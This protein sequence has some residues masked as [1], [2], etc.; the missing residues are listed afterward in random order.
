MP[1]VLLGKLR[2]KPN[3]KQVWLDWCKE[4]KRRKNEAIA[5]LKNA[6]VFSEACFISND[7]KFVYY[8]LEAKDVE[9]AMKIG[10]KSKHPIDKKTQKIMKA[11]LEFVEF[12]KPLYNFRNK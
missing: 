12:F 6:G 8:F 3:K 5:T 4:L 10:K 1:E 11:S 7:G 9:K 2:C